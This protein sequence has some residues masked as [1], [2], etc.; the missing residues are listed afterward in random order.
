VVKPN[1]ERDERGIGTDRGGLLRFEGVHGP[2]ELVADDVRRVS[3]ALL[4]LVTAAEKITFATA[5]SPPPSDS[6]AYR[7]YRGAE[8]KYAIEGF[9]TMQFANMSAFDH[10]R[11][12]VSLIRTATV[13][14]TALATVARGGLESL[15]R[16]WHLLTRVDDD[17]FVFRV[18]SLLRAD[19]RYSEILGETV[20]TRDGDSVDPAVKREF[21]ASELRRLRLP[22]PARTELAEMVAVMLD[23]EMDGGLG[24]SRYSDLSSIAHAHRLGINTFITTSERGEIS[25]LAAPRPVV[26]DM[27]ASLFAGAYGTTST[28]V[29]FYGDQTRHR[30]LLETAMQRALRT[31]MPI[32][33]SIWPD[34]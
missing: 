19:L 2:D 16:S 13:R 10:M 33:D 17:D 34:V 24:R 7:L 28:F 11:G 14:S 3:S 15:A 27:V 4:M 22:A 30:E 26:M 20:R 23:A 9:I 25:G 32:M 8:S 21:Y 12:F 1:S 6:A 29:E 18:I 5:D 31:V